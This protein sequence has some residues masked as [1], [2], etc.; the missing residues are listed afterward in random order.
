MGIKKLNKFLVK[1]CS[2]KAISN[3]HLSAFGE[4]TIVIDTSIY[5]YKFCSQDA[6]HENFYTLISKFRLYNITPLFIFDGK[7]PS[8]KSELLKE[9][10]IIKDDASVRYGEIKN[11][12]DGD[13]VVDK[14]MRGQLIKEMEILKRSC[15]RITKEQIQNVK[16]IMDSYGITYHTAEGEADKECAYMVANGKA[17]A[18]M[19]DDMDMFVY[20]CNHVLRNLNLSNDTIVMYDL[21]YILSDIKWTFLEFRQI[22]VLSGTDYNI[23]TETSLNETLRWFKQYRKQNPYI[24]DVGGVKKDPFEF[25]NWIQSNT[26][27]IENMDVLMDIYNMFCFEKGD[28]P[29]LDIL[30]IKINSEYDVNQLHAIMNRHGFMFAT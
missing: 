9:R 21:K 30:E 15:T 26:K 3:V 8:E 13:D 1:Y 6:L 4:K 16:E 14:K 18:C 2:D 5:L 23:N 29:H 24:E 20:G 12:L 10:K 25:Y 11:I 19:S 7:P 27:Y 17:H 28:Y 22:T